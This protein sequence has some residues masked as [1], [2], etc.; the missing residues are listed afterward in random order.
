MS[1][2]LLT[3]SPFHYTLNLFTYEEA[4]LFSGIFYSRFILFLYKLVSFITFKIIC[5]GELCLV[6]HTTQRS[7][8][9]LASSAKYLPNS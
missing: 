5:G 2:E 8:S 1:G 7:E 4:L 3:I 9:S 6:I